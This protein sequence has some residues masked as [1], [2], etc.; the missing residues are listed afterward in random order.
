MRPLGLL[1]LREVVELLIGF[2]AEF[3]EL[4]HGSNLERQIDVLM[5]NIEGV[6]TVE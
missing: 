5:L 6:R 2:L 1:D 3:H 4:L